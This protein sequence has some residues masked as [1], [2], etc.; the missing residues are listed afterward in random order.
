MHGGHWATTTIH[1]TVE[2]RLG[3]CSSCG[4]GEGMD[5]QCILEVDEKKARCLIGYGIG[6]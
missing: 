3:L 4:D 5:L 1:L 6:D 2:G